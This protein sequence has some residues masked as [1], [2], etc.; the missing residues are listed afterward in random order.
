M[1]Q[2]PKNVSHSLHVITKLGNIPNEHKKKNEKVFYANI[3]VL[4]VDSNRMRAQIHDFII[5]HAKYL[6]NVAK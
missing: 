2:H 5:V 4:V 1:L 3:S 6:I